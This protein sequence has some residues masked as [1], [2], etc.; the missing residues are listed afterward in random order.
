MKIKSTK[1]I[2]IINFIIFIV[3]FGGNFFIEFLG[4]AW[5]YTLQS[6]QYWRLLTC[7]FVHFGLSHIICNSIS[8]LQLGI[9]IESIYGSKKFALIYLICGLGSSFC[10]A[11]INMIFQRNVISAGASG[12]ICGLIGLLLSDIKGNK[13]GKLINIIICI[14]P[15]VII[16]F[17]P[18][19]DNIA[20]FSGVFIG[21]L[22]G[23]I[24]HKKRH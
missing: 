11:F 17:T 10:S 22:I 9:L 24:I 16:G 1:T 14:I 3:T 8:L 21:F 12:A 6:Y 4:N 19:V 18:G 5:P 20:H 13:K 23:R 15:I 7:I 2:L